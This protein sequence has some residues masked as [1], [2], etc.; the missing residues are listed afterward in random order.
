MS[1]SKLGN[2]EN[3]FVN[4]LRWAA[5]VEKYARQMTKQGNDESQMKSKGFFFFEF[6]T[7]T[8]SVNSDIQM[9]PVRAQEPDGAGRS[10]DVTR[11]MSTGCRV[12]VTLTISAGLRFL[13]RTVRSS[14]PYGVGPVAATAGAGAKVDD[15]RRSGSGS[16]S[17]RSKGLITTDDHDRP[18]DARPAPLV[19]FD[20]FGP[21]SHEEGESAVPERPRPLGDVPMEFSE[22]ENVGCDM[23]VLRIFK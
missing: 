22:E 1:C 9:Y 4:S 12:T 2:C 20:G 21:T 8:C 15:L 6:C 3:N 23:D 11:G 13:S 17:N 14:C 5:I 7:F 18:A 19:A 16:G 10:R